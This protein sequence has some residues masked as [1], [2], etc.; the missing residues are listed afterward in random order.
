MIVNLIKYIIKNACKERANRRV[1]LIDDGIQS[2]Y[3]KTNDCFRTTLS[4]N[5]EV[6]TITFD[7]FL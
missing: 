5:E 2:K 3:F 6:F 4:D 1:I 7:K